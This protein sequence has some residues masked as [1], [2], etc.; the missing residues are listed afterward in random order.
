VLLV[1]ARMAPLRTMLAQP[2]DFRPCVQA[3]LLRTI[4]AGCPF[5][6]FVSTPRLRQL[7]GD[8]KHDQVKYQPPSYVRVR[9]AYN[10]IASKLVSY[11]LPTGVLRSGH[12]GWRYRRASLWACKETYSG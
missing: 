10:R 9:H 3:G 1:S 12:K 11:A 7:S 2:P 6:D 5:R 8:Q 4:A